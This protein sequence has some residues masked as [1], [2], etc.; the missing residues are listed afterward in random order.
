MV[1]NLDLCPN[2]SS[3]VHTCNSSH[4]SDIAKYIIFPHISALQ[5]AGL[6]SL[7][8]RLRYD[9]RESMLVAKPVFP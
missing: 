2:T 4:V 9:M 7:F 3:L 8:P 6:G 5:V 1:W